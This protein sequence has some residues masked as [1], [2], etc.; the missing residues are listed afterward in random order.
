MHIQHVMLWKFENKN[1]TETPKKISSVYDQDLIADHQDQNWFSKFFSGDTS[2]RDEH[3][4]G[5]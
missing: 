5:Q 3:R 2:S 1:S 4:L